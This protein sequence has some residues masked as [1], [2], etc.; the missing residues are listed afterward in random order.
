MGTP[1][2]T[3]KRV[4]WSRLQDSNGPASAAIPA[5]LNLVAWGNA[6]AAESALH[7]LRERVCQYGFVVQEATTAT[8]PFLWE[9]VQA[10]H[11][12]CRADVLTL[13]KDIYEARQWEDLVSAGPAP[14][15][16]EDRVRWERDA[17]EAV[18]AGIA[19]AQALR[20]DPD[21]VI[22]RAAA[23]LAQALAA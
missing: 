11:I 17:R 16:Y 4:P 7:D 8:V 14:R 20:G 1:L 13:L 10:P 19:A 18:R 21:T 3:V 9:L 2:K 15:G 23:E 6:A 5:L 22:A 12:T